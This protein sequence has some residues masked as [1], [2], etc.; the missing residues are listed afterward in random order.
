MFNAPESPEVNHR[1]V[2]IVAA[3]I[4]AFLLLFLLVLSLTLPQTIHRPAPVIASFPAPSVT[5]DER[6]QRIELE[7]AQNERLRGING[8]MPIDE[9]MSAIAA[10]GAAAYDPIM[11][12]A[13]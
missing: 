10:K 8:T 4:L 5:T 2:L 7:R 12:S 3:G 9:A 11:G 13:Q 1:G 6:T